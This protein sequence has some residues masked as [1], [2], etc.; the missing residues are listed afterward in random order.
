[1][2][3]KEALSLSSYAIQDVQVQAK[4]QEV[5]FWSSPS[6]SQAECTRHILFCVK[7]TVSNRS[8]QS[9]DF[10]T[11]H[12]NK[13]AL[14]LDI[15]FLRSLGGFIFLLI[16]F[17]LRKY[18]V[19]GLKWVVSWVMTLVILSLVLSSRGSAFFY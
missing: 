11:L 12:T 15:H 16:T 18:C 14:V 10:L 4:R 2:L 6:G 7:S 9:R 1:M 5:A 17:K 13:Q 8:I 19:F 3:F